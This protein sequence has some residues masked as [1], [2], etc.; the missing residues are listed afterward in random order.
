MMKH[1]QTILCIALAFLF[2][3]CSLPRNVT[4]CDNGIKQTVGTLTSQVDSLI[5]ELRKLK[6]PEKITSN[7]ARGDVKYS[8]LSKQAFQ[9]E[10]GTCWVL[11]DSTYNLKES[12][13]YL[14]YNKVLPT[15]LPD[16]RGVFIRGMMTSTNASAKKHGDPDGIRLTG[17]YQKDSVGKHRHNLQMAT[18]WGQDDDLPPVAPGWS[19]KNQHATGGQNSFETTFNCEDCETRPKNISLFIYIKVCNE[20]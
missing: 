12:D 5:T 10:N 4:N 15:K 2:T 20:R 8:I 3:A 16:G 18:K 11:L 19:T 13:L 6:E 1:S 17:G 14:R 7:G 9:E